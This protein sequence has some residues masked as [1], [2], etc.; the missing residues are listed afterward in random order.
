[1]LTNVVYNEYIGVMKALDRPPDGMAEVF[2]HDAFLG[3]LR[4]AEVLT[5]SLSDT[6]RPFRLTLGQYSVLRA[7]RLS[8]EEGL[9]C[10]EVS[11]RLATRAPDITRLLDRLELL[12]FVSRRRERPDRRVVRTHITEQGLGVLRALDELVGNLQTRHLGH[13]GARKLGV[14]RALLKTTAEPL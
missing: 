9:T 1:V 6:L 2:E 3:I 7:L 4:M 14:F 13:L 5:R 8:E 10:A 11:D 12:G